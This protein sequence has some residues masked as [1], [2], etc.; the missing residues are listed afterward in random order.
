MKHSDCNDLPCLPAVNLLHNDNWLELC[1]VSTDYWYHLCYILIVGIKHDVIKIL[2]L[3]E[4]QC[5]FKINQKNSELYPNNVVKK[6]VDPN[7]LRF[8]IYPHVYKKIFEF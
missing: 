5:K 6:Y 8:E 2:N 4:I 3:R 1:Y 7:P